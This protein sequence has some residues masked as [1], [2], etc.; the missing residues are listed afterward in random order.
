MTRKRIKKP[1]QKRWIKTN[2]FLLE[3]ADKRKRNEEGKDIKKK[4]K[5]R[6]REIGK[7]K[8]RT[9][10]KGMRKSNTRKVDENQDKVNKKVRNENGKH[11]G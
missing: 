11:D 3:A 7:R 6:T 8:S 1:N 4:K 5:F 9:R 2:F 10:E